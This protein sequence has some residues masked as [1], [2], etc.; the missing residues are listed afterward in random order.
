MFDSND[1]YI[2]NKAC[3]LCGKPIKFGEDALE[4]LTPLSRGGTNN[5]ENLGVAHN[6]FSKEKCNNRKATKTM[7]EFMRRTSN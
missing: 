3:I 7:Q 4:H 2:K 5:Y 6:Q 1:Y